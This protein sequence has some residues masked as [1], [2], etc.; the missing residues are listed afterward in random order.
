MALK[1]N[2]PPPR[3]PAPV[4]R[5]AAGGGGRAA[6]D[7][8]GVLPRGHPQAGPGA[9]RGGGNGSIASIIHPCAFFP[10][11]RCRPVGSEN[12]ECP[13]QKSDCLHC[14]WPLALNISPA[15]KGEMNTFFWRGVT[16]RGSGKIF[17]RC[18]H[19][20]KPLLQGLYRRGVSWVI[21]EIRKVP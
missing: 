2:A 9:E 5:G 3:R 18:R 8:D 6:A 14:N 13:F 11:I 20:Q 17:R 10:G 15:Q 16:D 21:T 19:K 1:P 12:D 4:P 7:P